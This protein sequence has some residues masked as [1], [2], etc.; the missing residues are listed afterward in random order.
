MNRIHVG[1]TM[2]LLIAT[3]LSAHAQSSVTIYGSIDATIGASKTTAGTT[4]PGGVVTVATPGGTI[5]RM[6]SSVGPSSRLGF[7]GSEDLW[8]GLKANFVL[9]QGF[10][11]D[12]GAL[13]QGGLAFGRQAFVGLSSTAGWSV[14]VGRQYSPMFLGFG[15]SDALAGTYWGNI[16]NNSGLGIYESLSSTPGGGAF[17]SAGRVDNSFLLAW[18]SGPVAAKL[19]LGAGNENQRGTG[20]LINPHISYTSGPLQINASYVRVRQ[21]S[22]SITATADPEWLSEWLVGG[23]YN[24]G[25]VRLFTG[26]FR[27]NGPKD[28]GNLSAAAKA[29][30]F[31]YTWSKTNS[32]WL[33]A[34]I[35]VG[36]QDMFIAQVA[37]TNY[38]YSSGPSGKGL[39]L[40]FVYEH[41]LSKRTTLY[42]NYGQTNNNAYAKGPLNAAVPV[43]LSNGYGGDQKALAFG[44]RHTF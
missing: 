36:V 14:S 19:M 28:Q 6:D 43:I 3:A 13:Q 23:S 15:Q 26:Y 41:A 11:V 16:A 34:Q 10:G 33:G 39:V 1:M 25:P 42:A 9:E 12:T 31:S 20:R 40:G 32:V 22:E 18:T 35:P 30:P 17:Q 37:R 29:S 5:T 8:S 27:L 38:D 4:T 21:N 24:F 2:P 44:V 7:R